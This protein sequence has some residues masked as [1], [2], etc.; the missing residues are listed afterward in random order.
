MSWISNVMGSGSAFGDILN[1]AG[2]LYGAYSG[3]SAANSQNNAGKASAKIAGEQWGYQKGFADMLTSLMKDPSSITKQPGYQFGMDQGIQALTR[4]MAATGY[5]GSGNEMIALQQYGQQYASQWLLQQ[6]QLLANISG[7]ASYNPSGGNVNA[8]NIAGAANTTTNNTLGSLSKAYQF[9]QNPTTSYGALPGMGTDASLGS[10][11]AS[12][13]LGSNGAGGFNVPGNIMDNPP[14]FNAGSGAADASGSG[15]AAAGAG[16]GLGAIASTLGPAAPTFT[17]GVEGVGDALAGTAAGTAAAAAG[18]EALTP[19][20]TTA[21]A[22]WGASAAGASSAGGGAATGGLLASTAWMLPAAMVAALWAGASAQN[23]DTMINPLTGQPL[24]SGDP[25]YGKVAEF[26]APEM[27]RQGASNRAN[28]ALDPAAAGAYGSA[29][30]GMSPGQQMQLLSQTQF[31]QDVSAA[32]AMPQMSWQDLIN[33][34]IST[35][36]NPS[37]MLPQYQSMYQSMN[38]QSAPGPKKP[39]GTGG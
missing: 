31:G 14:N 25:F 22:A 23:R 27:A 15:A 10:S 6:E 32:N 11:A 16:A 2:T 34:Y 19:V 21:P 28:A 35:G 39:M 33:L 36:H 24:T 3:F 9:F 4:G 12:N 13:I 29:L 17:V 8:A 20:V 37:T 1:T 7:I 38:T 26:L 5:T 18:A 30:A